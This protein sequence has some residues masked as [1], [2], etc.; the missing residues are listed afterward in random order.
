MKTKLIA[1]ALLFTVVNVFAF[2][3]DNK[4]NYRV[5]VFEGDG[6]VW[7]WS[8]REEVSPHETSKGEPDNNP[9]YI[10]ANWDYLDFQHEDK[11]CC[12]IR[13]H[14]KQIITGSDKKHAPIAH[15]N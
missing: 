15:C 5:Y 3:T 10:C 14:G 4:T 8:Y 13:P 6:K 11:N 12:W 9:R 1:V 2:N 7:R